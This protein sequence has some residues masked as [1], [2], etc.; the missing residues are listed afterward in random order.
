MISSF[1]L[2]PVAT[3][4]LLAKGATFLSMLSLGQSVRGR[5]EN[6]LAVAV[7]WALR[8]VLYKQEAAAERPGYRTYDDFMD[9]FLTSMRL[10]IESLRKHA[11]Y[12]G[13]DIAD[14]V[15]EVRTLTA[16]LTGERVRTSVQAIMKR[17][18]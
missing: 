13:M 9:P 8:G 11:K 7:E 12:L 3:R 16:Q 6:L 18:A 5:N 14:D 17:P 15:V 2:R 1:H 10:Q 4:S